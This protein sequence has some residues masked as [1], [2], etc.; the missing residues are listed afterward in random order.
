MGPIATAALL[1]V[2]AGAAV[3]LVLGAPQ[4][5]AG[6]LPSQIGSSS[7]STS[8]SSTGPPSTIPITVPAT[9]PRTTATTRPPATT[10]T[11]GR[12]ATTIR[13]GGRPAVLTVPVPFSAGVGPA[14]TTA[15][16]AT[17][18]TIAGIGGHFPAAPATVPLRTSGTNGH[19]NPVFAWLSGVGLAIALLILCARLFV[20]RSG[21][22]DR[23]PL[24]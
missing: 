12:T 21:G 1:M 2:A 11:T 22:R 9:A 23:A 18:T 20:T 5:R 14:P 15:V 19:V 8:P 16:P 24:T 6:Q 4:A 10:A 17:T 13:A 7:S 3:G